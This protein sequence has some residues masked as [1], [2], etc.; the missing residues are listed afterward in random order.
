M[1]GAYDTHPKRMEAS[2]TRQLS[3]HKIN[4]FIRLYDEKAFHAQ[5]T[6]NIY[7]FTIYERAKN[8]H[9]HHEFHHQRQQM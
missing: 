7:V 4:S 3:R 8:K 5:Q 6:C 9:H 1:F 2:S